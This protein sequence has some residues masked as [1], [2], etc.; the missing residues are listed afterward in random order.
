MHDTI[1]NKGKPLLYWCYYYYY[2][3]NHPPEMSMLTSLTA[4]CTHLSCEK[5]LQNPWSSLWNENRSILKFKKVCLLDSRQKKKN[6]NKYQ[7]SS[8]SI[9]VIV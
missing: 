4:C 5:A 8:N 3:Y 9:V 1:I 2:Y 7:Y 6:S